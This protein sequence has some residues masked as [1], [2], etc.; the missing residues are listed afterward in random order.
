MPDRHTRWYQGIQR[1]YRNA[2]V[3]HIRTVLR[4][5]HPHDWERIIQEPFA[6]EWPTVVERAELPRKVGA[7]SSPIRDAADYLGVNHFHNLFEVHFD[8]LFPPQESTDTYTRRQEKASVLNWAREIKIVR[9]PESHPPTEDMAFDDVIRQLDTAGRICA[10]F[11]RQAADE[12]LALKQQLYSNHPTD[13]G[14]EDEEEYRRPPLQ[15]SLPPRESISPQFIG[16]EDEL[17][18]LNDWLQDSSSRVWLL[19]GDGGKGKTAIAYQ[20]ATLTQ[21]QSPEPFEFILWLSAKR[22]QF[23]ERQIADVTDPDFS[24]LESALNYMLTEY[25][26]LGELPSDLDGKKQ[27]VLEYLELL[28]SLVVLDDINS[29]EGDIVNSLSFFMSEAVRTRSKFLLT[30]R[31]IPF[32]MDTLT[33]QISGFPPRSA[34]GHKFVESRIRLFGLDRSAFDTRTVNSILTVT[35]GSPLYIEDLLR[36]ALLGED[37]RTVCTEWRDRKGAAARKYALGREF[38]RLTSDA[39]EVLLA[40]ALF[41]APVSTSE[42]AV[43]AGR[44]F[45]VDRVQN[46][47]VELQNLFLVPKPRIVEDI[48]RFTLN[49]NTR[50][51]VLDVGQNTNPDR[52]ER[53]A[54]A[55]SAVSGK[56]TGLDRRDRIVVG[57]YTR[58]A[59]SLVKLGS[60]AEA[61]NTLK[62]G[63][64]A[65]PETPDLYGQLGWVYKRWKPRDT[66]NNPSARLNFLC[67]ELQSTDLFRPSLALV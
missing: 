23:V 43:A 19:A 45:D 26:F 39:H 5:N 9:D 4:D 27:A 66:L 67:V 36:L 46:A 65:L 29:L 3:Q 28:P 14:Q 53:I 59:I 15:A 58:Q 42:I 49:Q 12:L 10:K 51:L 44:D 41:G 25:G 13:F 52:F 30:S 54:A 61:E 16:R 38:D 31:L 2:V 55:I 20:F 60:S 56:R 48:P 32:G 50:E 8:V 11:S 63:L 37:L 21:Q 17:A 64:E 62:K 35:D 34:D 33:T 24:D 57:S 22:R 7:I 47:L 1:I 18:M 6:K 40:A